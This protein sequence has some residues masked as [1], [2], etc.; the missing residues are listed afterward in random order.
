MDYEKE[1]GLNVDEDG[2]VFGK[3]TPVPKPVAPPVALPVLPD[4]T[5]I[6]ERAKAVEHDIFKTYYTLMMAE[7]TPPAIKKSCADALADRA[8][9]KPAQSM[10][11]SAKVQIE[12]LI[13]ECY[14]P[15]K[16]IEGTAIEVKA[17]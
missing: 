10:D 1:Y 6:R 7:N 14:P 5:D 8:R 16:T 11:I 9:G 13:V 17:P 4:S 15:E 12:Q 3:Q 2:N